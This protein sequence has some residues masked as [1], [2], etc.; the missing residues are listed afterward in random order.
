MSDFYQAGQRKGS[1]LLKGK[2]NVYI[3]S[4]STGERIELQEEVIQ[5]DDVWDKVVKS[6]YNSRSRELLTPATVLGI[7]PSIR[8]TKRNTMPVLAVKTAD[9]KFEILS[10]MKRSF[11]VSISPGCE[12]L[13]HFASSMSEEDKQALAKTADLHEKPSFLDVALT[14]LEYKKE[15]GSDFSLRNAAK[16]FDVSKSSIGD[17]IKFAELPIELFKLFP[18]ASYVTWDFL[19]KVVAAE[20]TNEDIIKAIAKI[21]PVKASEE[22]I[23][24]ED[25]EK[26]LRSAS[27]ALETHILKAISASLPS[28]DEKSFDKRSPFHTSKLVK[29]VK[30]KPST[31]GS[32]TIKFDKTIIESKLGKDLLA[33]ISKS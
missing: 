24:E 18:G 15:V 5:S 7:L 12:L 27:K 29:G 20:V 14:L 6:K 19:K 30:A 16:I 28:P 4:P 11:A 25:G 3:T 8:E 21:E 26:N 31:N 2:S 1:L 13:V 10:G 33:L 17:L 23:A 32:V 22:S 9:G